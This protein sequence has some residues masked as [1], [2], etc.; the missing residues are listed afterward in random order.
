M[1]LADLDDEIEA[2]ARPKPLAELPQSWL[3]NGLYTLTFPCGTRKTLKVH[4]QKT[5][6]L[7]G[8]RLVS[9]LTGPTNT[10]DFEAFA[11]LIPTAPGYWVWKRFKS[12]RQAAYPALLVS[13]AK[14]EEIDGHEL[15]VSR[16]CLRCNRVLTTPES[17]AKGVGP[18]CERRG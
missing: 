14:G 18:E 3:A 5:G 15:H 7:G 8:K 11:E 13:L 10:A 12:A 1:S 17:I 4:T 2:A 16:H 6:P 9:L